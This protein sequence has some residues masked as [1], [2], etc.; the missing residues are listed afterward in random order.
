MGV[1]EGSIIDLILQYLYILYYIYRCRLSIDGNSKNVYDKWINDWI[2]WFFVIFI[3]NLEYSHYTKQYKDILQ[4]IYYTKGV[5]NGN[6]HNEN[7]Y[8]VI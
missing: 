6:P 7:I 8:K 1:Y 3:N 4:L 5:P 2:K